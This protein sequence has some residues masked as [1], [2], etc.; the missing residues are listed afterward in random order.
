MVLCDTD[1]GEF[2]LIKLS[3]EN[4]SAIFFYLFRPSWVEFGNEFFFGLL[5]PYLFRV[6]YFVFFER[7]EKCFEIFLL[8]VPQTID[9]KNLLCLTKGNTPNQ[10]ETQ[11]KKRLEN[12]R[13]DRW[14]KNAFF[15][16]KNSIFHC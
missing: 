14:N 11:T 9:Q 3:L 10:P 15:S 13:D 5:F 12:L 8:F 7:V 1:L 16:T 2:I 6:V 4:I